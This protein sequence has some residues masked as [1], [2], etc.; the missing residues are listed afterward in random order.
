[1]K[2][3]LPV[4]VAA[5][6]VLALV[7]RANRGLAAEG[8]SSRPGFSIRQQG[9]TAWLLRPNGQP[10]FS[11]G[12]ACV[13]QGASR[14]EFDHANPGY[15]AWQHYADANLWAK[16]TLQRLQAW[17]FTTVG[18]WSDFEV[19]RRSAD[20]TLA[21]AP[22]LHVGSTAGAP[23]WDMWDAHNLAR[24][25][26]VARDQI[27]PLRDDPRVL[28]YYSD[29]EIGWWNAI[30]FK[31]T[32]EQ[33]STS[34]Q[35]QRLLRLLHETYQ[36]DW[37]ALLKDFEPAPGVEGWE[38]LSRHGLLFLRPGGKG[39]QVERKFLALLAER[40][41]A[42]VH[43]IIRKYAPRALVLG[44]RYQSFYY[45]EVARAWVRPH[46][47]GLAQNALRHRRRLVPVLRSADAWA[48]RR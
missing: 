23:W 32:L 1:V 37:S 29:N 41:Y 44:D 5:F 16:A 9:E 2:V 24:M 39:I 10:F 17:G 38:S 18:G 7:V 48:I 36:D 27:L 45:P 4:R 15:A 20:G 35:R 6:V 42:V 43:D 13:N 12:V 31:M 21:F 46:A 34:G 25:D 3:A 30:L 19:L 26:A 11:L 8:A 33:A 47:P 22:V 40:Y 28:G 14:E